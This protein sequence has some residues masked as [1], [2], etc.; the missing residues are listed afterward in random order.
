MHIYPIN[1]IVDVVNNDIGK[2][3]NLLIYNYLL[4][5]YAII[6]PDL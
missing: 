2:Y 3:S 1:A 4:D 6:L 5:N